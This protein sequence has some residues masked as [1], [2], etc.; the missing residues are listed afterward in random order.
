MPGTL[1]IEYPIVDWNRLGAMARVLLGG[2][3]ML[4]AESSQAQPAVKQVLM[5]QSLHR[6]NL[7]LDRFTGDLRVDLDQRAGRPVNMVQVV[8]GASGFVEASEQALVAYIQSMYADRAPDLIMTAGGPAAAFVRRHRRELFPATPLLFGAVDQRYLAGAPLGANEAAV[9]VINDFPAL[10][11]D[12]LRALPETRE[13]FVV[14]GSGA[15][16]KFWHRELEAGFARFRDRV[17]FTWSFD[18]SL[19]DILRR[20]ASLPRGSAI[21]Y[22]TFGTDA[23]GGAYADEQVL[24][25]LHAR[26]N[27]PLFGAHTS[28]LGHGIVGGSL[29]AVGDLAQDTAGVAIRL[30]NGE[31]PADVRPPPRSHGPAVYDWRE[32]QRWQIPESRLPPGSLVQFRGP[33]LWDEHWGWVLATVAALLLQ[34]L[35]IT[36]FI[37][38][39]RARRR[40]EIESRRNLALA[41]DADRRQT[42]SALASS[43]GHELAQPLSSIAFNA[44]ALK[45]LVSSGEQETQPTVE[46]LSEIQSEASLARQIIDRHRAMLRSR[47]LQKRPIDLHGVIH[48]SLALVAHDLKARHVETKLHLST[49][50]CVVNGDPV[51]LEQV[52]VNLVRNAIDALAEA[53]PARR[54]ITLR[55]RVGEAN[56]EISVSDTGTGLPAEVAD[57]LFA[58]FV[59]TKPDGLGIG[60]AIAQRIVDAHAGTIQAAQNPGGGAT[61][62]IMLPSATASG[63]TARIPIEAGSA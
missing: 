60:L 57:T 24:A 52:V 20:C 50:A 38:E 6:G 2:L 13:V 3:M 42:I 36:W 26:A 28:Y 47:E 17:T 34:S 29:M 59:S 58:P 40:A 23:L 11:D 18:L 46:A 31:A 32:L 30:L 45:R 44:A 14:T 51:L 19:E 62:T 56:V 48:E 25:A 39:W 5:I 63:A 37:Y 55:S 7:I 27:A 61:F 41:A 35:L 10:V 49:A 4:A 33:T 43:I 21:L 16:A 22:L 15:L 8:V 12:V 53:A 1:P 9:A 54:R